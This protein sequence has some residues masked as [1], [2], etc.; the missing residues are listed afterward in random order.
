MSIMTW[1]RGRVDDRPTIV[2][3]FP[4]SD[5]M[6]TVIHLVEQTLAPITREGYRLK[7]DGSCNKAPQG[8]NWEVVIEFESDAMADVVAKSMITWFGPPQAVEHPAS[9]VDREGSLTPGPSD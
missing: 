7:C 9:L 6:A 3:E 1:G 5:E 8:I 2:V 4:N